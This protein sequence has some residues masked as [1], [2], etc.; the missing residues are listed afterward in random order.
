MVRLS[1]PCTVGS[2]WITRCISSGLEHQPYCLELTSMYSVLMKIPLCNHPSMHL[3]N[4][5]LTKSRRVFVSL[6]SFL[7]FLLALILSGLQPQA[8]SD[9]R[10]AYKFCQF[11]KN[12]QLR[13]FPIMHFFV[14]TCYLVFLVA[15][16]VVVATSLP[17]SPSSGPPDG[18]SRRIIH[19]NDPLYQPPKGCTRVGSRSHLHDIELKRVRRD[20]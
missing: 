9:K 6:L 19:P 11:S 1:W 4:F 7:S 13:P 8:L 16:L 17:Q 12:L 2:A 14:A 3:T 18:I 20:Y 5:P 10:L 15:S